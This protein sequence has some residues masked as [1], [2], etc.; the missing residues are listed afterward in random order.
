VVRPVLQ[1]TRFFDAE[2][3]EAQTNIGWMKGVED[4][5][6][7]E[8]RIVYFNEDKDRGREK[9]IPLWGL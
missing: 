3:N 6:S 2:R 5:I 7:S 4:A 8:D 1:E 9:S